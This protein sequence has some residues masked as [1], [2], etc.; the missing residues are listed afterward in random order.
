MNF[1]L[2]SKSSKRFIR[3]ETTTTRIS[4]KKGLSGKGPINNNL[5][6]NRILYH[7]EQD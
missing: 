2:C 4:K 7:E 5:Q 3:D 6:V 1:G